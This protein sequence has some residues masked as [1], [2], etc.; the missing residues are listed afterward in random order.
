MKSKTRTAAKNKWWIKFNYNPWHVRDIGDCAIRAVV[1]AIGL[2]YKTVCKKLGVSYVLGRGL[3]R[4]TGIDLDKI[5]KTFKD[6]FGNIEDFAENNKF[7]PSEFEGSKV[8]DEITAIE[9]AN[10]IDSNISGLTLNEFCE[11]YLGLG[12]FLVSLSGDPASKD[13]NAREGGHI[14]CAKLAANAKKKGFVQ[15]WDSGNMKVDCYMEV[16]KKEPVDSPFHW[17]YD[18]EKK[19]FIV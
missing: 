3:R 4:D 11:L 18:Y 1:A 16:A 9:L 12:T 17:K 14:V 2:D 10:G 19:Q 15:T 13:A 8:N 6:Y 5:K 7:V